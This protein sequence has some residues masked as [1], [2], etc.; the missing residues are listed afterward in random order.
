[1]K[2]RF[3]C[4]PG[5]FET[6]PRPQTA[7]RMTPDWYRRMPMVQPLP[8]GGEDRTVKHCA[9]FLDAL[10]HGFMIPLQADIVV[11]DGKFS[12]DWDWPESPIASW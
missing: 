7:K 2:I 11:R 5:L 3:S 1:M 8:E 12:W 10:T 4:P 6:L 9:P